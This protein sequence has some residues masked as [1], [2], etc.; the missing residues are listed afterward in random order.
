MSIHL[1]ARIATD[2]WLTKERAVL[3]DKQEVLCYGDKVW[4]LL[5]AMSR[6]Q[7]LSL[8]KSV[9]YNSRQC[10]H[11]AELKAQTFPAG[12]ARMT[13][14]FHSRGLP[15]SCP[16]PHYFAACDIDGLDHVPITLV[17]RQD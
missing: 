2:P 17:P 16:Q 11:T 13:A 7:L 8:T 6:G 10:Q 1:S 12:D 15:Q 3:C 9:R 5:R 14:R 4:R